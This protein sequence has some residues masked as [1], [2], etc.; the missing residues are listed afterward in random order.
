MVGLGWTACAPPASGPRP[1]ARSAPDVGKLLAMMISPLSPA[2]PV[3]PPPVPPAPQALTTS[4]R[5]TRIAL[6]ASQRLCIPS[7]H[8]ILGL[9]P[10]CIPCA[11]D[12]RLTEERGV[13][14]DRREL[15]H[16]RW[17]HQPEGLR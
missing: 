3:A 13:F 8:F 7:S 10:S 14:D 15:T 4:A 9:L 5:P 17:N 16:H 11:S 2:P 12:P 1:L 6:A